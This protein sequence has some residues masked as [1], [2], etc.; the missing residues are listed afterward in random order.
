MSIQ[1]QIVRYAF[2]PSKT[3]KPIWVE[4]PADKELGFSSDVGN[5][6]QTVKNLA[7]NRLLTFGVGYESQKYE[8]PVTEVFSDGIE[9]KYVDDFSSLTPWNPYKVF[10]LPG[11]ILIGG[12][13]I[14]LLWILFSVIL[15]NPEYRNT[16]IEIGES[17]LSGLSKSMI[18]IFE[19]NELKK[20]FESI[21]KDKTE[22]DA[23][24]DEQK[25]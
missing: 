16:F 4:V 12:V 21:K 8:P 17:V 1:G 10:Y 14:T 13:A 18:T 3:D 2:T 22:H 11:H 23:S 20:I 24:A 15:S 19:F 5:I 7:P 25:E 6:V 9:C